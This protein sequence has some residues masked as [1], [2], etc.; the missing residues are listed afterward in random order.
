MNKKINILIAFNIILTIAFIG[1]IYLNSFSD[2]SRKVSFKEISVE[3]INIIE[4]DG[5]PKI[6]ITKKDNLQN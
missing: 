5:S 6:I 3:R 4:K 2:S 1:H